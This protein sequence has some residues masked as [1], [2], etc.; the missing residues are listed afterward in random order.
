MSL[1]HQIISLHQH[2]SK[3]VRE[4]ASDLSLPKSTVADIIRKYEE[5]VTVEVNRK[6]HCGPKEK[7]SP[8]SKKAIIREVQRDPTVTVAEI[9]K[10]NPEIANSVSRVTVNRILLKFGYR[11][12]KPVKKFYLSPAM[13]KRR[14]E[15]A[16]QMLSK[17]EDFWEKVRLISLI[18]VFFL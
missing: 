14:M 17:S 8:R 4:I 6:G 7:L 9:L 16:R 5:I 1:R 10:S 11:S 2:T 15:W 3:S 13:K 12:H 18:W